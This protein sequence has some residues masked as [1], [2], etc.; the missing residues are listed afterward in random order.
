MDL[1]PTSKDFSDAIT[2]TPGIKVDR[3]M[4]NSGLNNGFGLITSPDGSLKASECQRAK[5]MGSGYISALCKTSDS[6]YAISEFIT[7][8][9]SLSLNPNQNEQKKNTDSQSNPTLTLTSMNVLSEGFFPSD[10]VL[11]TNTR[12]NSLYYGAVGFSD[13]TDSHTKL[14]F[15]LPPQTDEPSDALLTVE[16]QAET[17]TSNAR[18]TTMNSD[19]A[20]AAY[21]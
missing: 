2:T 1:F 12:D 10:H 11:F 4:E 7:G 15:E 13:N 17:W 18:I 5:H 14:L 8:D 20:L 21:N 16:L 3:M 19:P 9:S 6:K